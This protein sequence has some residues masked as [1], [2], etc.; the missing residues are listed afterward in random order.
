M[1]RLIRALAALLAAGPPLLWAQTNGPSSD[2]DWEAVLPA[3]P[4]AS[5]QEV[6]A[7]YALL[8]EGLAFFASFTNLPSAEDYS[9]GSLTIAPWRSAFVVQYPVRFKVEIKA[10]DETQ[11]SLLYALQKE[12]PT[13]SW[14]MTEGWLVSPAGERIEAL[15]IPQAD[16]Q[17]LANAC[18]PEALSQMK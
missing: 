3:A 18:V 4:N 14:V 7:R 5:A 11:P 10:K 15:T 2:P 9:G 6:A 8:R 12:S 13:A 17:R 16:E 1:K